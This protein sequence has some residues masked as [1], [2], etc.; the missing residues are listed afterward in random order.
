[1]ESQ[2]QFSTRKLVDSVAEQQVLE[3][4]IEGQKP[5]AEGRIH[6]LL[7][8][9]FRYPPLR[10]GSRFGT[11][12][13]RG[14]W[15]GSEQ[16]RTSFAEAAYYRMLFL[17]GT[18]ADIAPLMV[19]VSAFRATYK[20]ERGVDLTRAPFATHESTISSP[21]SYEASQLLGEQMREDGVEAFRYRSAR[22]RQRGVNIGM[23]VPRVFGARRPSAPETWHCVA[24]RPEVEFVKKDVF[25]RISFHFPRQDFE[26]DGK[27]PSPAV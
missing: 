13:H 17:E 15:Y 19:E 4:L 20:T 25:Q 10:H 7:S 12:V 8:T 22:D 26:V 27:L 1:M 16:Q 6:Y 23:F 14:I 9:P 5:R 21:T 24:S 2:H 18:T 11:R 3:D